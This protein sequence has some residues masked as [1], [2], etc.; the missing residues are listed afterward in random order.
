MTDFA[1][2]PTYS[3]D[4]PHDVEWLDVKASSCLYF[5]G[6][7]KAPRFLLWVEFAVPALGWMALGPDDLFTTLQ[8][9]LEFVINSKEVE[10]FVS[11]CNK[12]QNFK[13]CLF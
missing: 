6:S 9:H 11:L 10:V 4:D 1:R 12:S 3:G 13:F 2:S 8:H 5:S 7:V